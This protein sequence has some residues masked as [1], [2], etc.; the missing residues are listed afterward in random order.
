MKNS[1]L[2]R[3]IAKH[4]G[5]V[6]PGLESLFNAISESYENYEDQ[7]SMLQRAMKISSDE[8]FAANERL[9]EEANGLKEINRNLE[10]ILNSMNTDTYGAQGTNF[11]ASE[12]IRG[13]LTKL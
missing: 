5:T 9:R 8:L 4:A 10:F 11:K 2:K 13:S 3:Q 6:P 12:Y 1:L 7:I